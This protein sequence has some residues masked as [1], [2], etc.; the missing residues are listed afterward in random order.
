MMVHTICMQ[1]TLCMPTRCRRLV[2]ALNE[3]AGKMEGNRQGSARR[4]S[5]SWRWRRAGRTASPHAFFFYFRCC[6]S[7]A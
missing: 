3:L 7:A 1:Q 4:M 5:G 2:S 6:A